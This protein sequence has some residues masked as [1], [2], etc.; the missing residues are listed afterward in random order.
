MKTQNPS[1]AISHAFGARRRLRFNENAHFGKFDAA[2]LHPVQCLRLRPGEGGTIT[3]ALNVGAAPVSGYMRSNMYLEVVQ[4]AVPYQSIEE[5]LYAE[6]MEDAGV[7]E[8][9]KRR[10]MAGGG[11]YHEEENVISKA[12][13][14]KP[15][16]MGAQKKV[17][18]TIRLAYI[19]SVN[20]LR[21]LSYY[22]AEQLPPT[23]T[24]IQPA[25]LTANVLERFQG[26]LDPERLIDGA[27]T[28]SGQLNVKGIGATTTT[29]FN[30]SDTQAKETGGDATYSSA[31]LLNSQSSG[32]QGLLLEEDPEN[33]GQPKIVAD[34]GTAG[35]FTL[36]DMMQSTA[37][38]GLVREFAALIQADPVKGEQRV[39]RALYGLSCDYD[40]TPQVIYRKVHELRPQHQRPTDGPS[41]N[42]VSGHFRYDGQFT[43]LVPR[44]E[45]GMQVITLVSLKPMETH[46]DQ[47]DPA[48]TE[49]WQLVNRIHDETQ[50]EE[51]LLT[52]ADLE[53]NVPQADADTPAFWVGHN[54]LEHHYSTVGPNAQQIEGVEMKSSMWT[55]P[56]PTSVTA[57]NVNY[58]SEGVV[59]YP[60][61]NWNGGHAEYT[62]RQTA[63]ISTGL[64]KGPTPIESIKLFEENPELVSEE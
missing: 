20:H 46:E 29:D 35:Q 16:R 5:T 9:T 3:T 22:G 19:A 50:L 31:A 27:I 52:R 53:S 12:C 33:P 30:V 21:S 47:P 32:F 7:T 34:L 48:Q 44:S 59:M 36:R 28:L 18:K 38:D 11:I 14:I 60:F 26:V 25:V 42:D 64:A 39:E 13:N 2:K 37:L 24:E 54:Q 49:P 6:T 56:V 58:P 40:A 45:L 61:Y 4:V 51:V 17:S 63:M 15:R 10:L 43:T 8:M 41:I 62:C 23:E 55:H 57:Q 1:R